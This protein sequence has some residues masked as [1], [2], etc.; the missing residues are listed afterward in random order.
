MTIQRFHPS[1]PR[2]TEESLRQWADVPVAVAGDALNRMQVMQSRI[3]P[4]T[5]KASMTGQAFTIDA[6]HGDNAAIHVGLTS[7][8]PGDVVVINAGG[9]ADRALYGGI[10]NQLAKRNQVTGSIIDGGV[11]DVEELQDQ[12][13]P[14]FAAGISPAGPSK[15]WGGAINA[16]ISCGGVVVQPGDLI[17][18]DADGIVVVPLARVDGIL[19]TSQS[20]LA[21]EHS[22]VDRIL[23]GEDTAD[24]FQINDI[25]EM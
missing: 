9:L 1:Y 3:R 22:I 18:T 16:P 11:R 19:A 5:Q 10:L 6:F 17:H 15:G 21:A 12:G 23:Q 25:E 4:I 2:L 7:V 24:I 20:R 13:L 8:Q 14:V